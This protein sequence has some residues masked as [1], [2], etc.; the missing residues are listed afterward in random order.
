MADLSN[1]QTQHQV[2]EHMK[3]PENMT[4]SKVKNKSSETD[5]RD[6]EVFELSDKEF[7]ITTIK[8]LNKLRKIMHKQNGTSIKKN[9]K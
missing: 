5:P 4:Q 1:V 2:T 9:K 8:M 6:M 3:R 7:K